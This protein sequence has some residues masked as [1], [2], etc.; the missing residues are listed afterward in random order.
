MKEDRL[1]QSQVL[2]HLEPRLW[3]KYATMEGNIVEI[4]YSTP[5]WVEVINYRKHL[6]ACQPLQT[7]TTSRMRIGVGRFRV[8]RFDTSDSIYWL[9]IFPFQHVCFPSD[10]L[11]SYM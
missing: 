2:L 9:Y 3:Q 7:R 8:S 4:Q 10:L 11:T 5:V 1:C 6:S